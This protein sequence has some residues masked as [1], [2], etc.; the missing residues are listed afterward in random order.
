MKIVENESKEIDIWIGEN[1]RHALIQHS[2][3]E[4]VIRFVADVVHGNEVIGYLMD[5]AKNGSLL[6][7]L[8]AYGTRQSH[9]GILRC[10]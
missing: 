6:D 9:I 2:R 5:D 8:K 4:H 10:K 3:N 1:K 7:I